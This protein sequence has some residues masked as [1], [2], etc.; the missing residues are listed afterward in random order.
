MFNFLG[1]L[2]TTCL[3]LVGAQENGSLGLVDTALT[4]SEMNGGSGYYENW[5]CSQPD[6][7]CIFLLGL[8][9]ALEP[10]T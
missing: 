8:G 9:I 2:L 4:G 3:I 5:V 7:Y 10:I 1:A 6:P